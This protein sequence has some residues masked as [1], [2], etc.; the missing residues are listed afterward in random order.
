ME[1]K[2]VDSEFLDQTLRVWQPLSDKPLDEEGARESI[3]N[4]SG[5][6][7]LLAEWEADDGKEKG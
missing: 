2:H 5:F 7:D 3:A 4:I 1:D 6:F